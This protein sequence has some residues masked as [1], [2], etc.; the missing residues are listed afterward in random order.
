MR[1]RVDVGL[2]G[3]HVAPRHDGVRVRVRQLTLDENEHQFSFVTCEISINAF[4]TRDL[5]VKLQ[6][7]LQGVVGGEA[8]DSIVGD[9]MLGPALWALYLLGQ[10]TKEVGELLD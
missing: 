6:E 8:L 4:L 2:L 3:A 1:A 9:A 7:L 5:R 10:R